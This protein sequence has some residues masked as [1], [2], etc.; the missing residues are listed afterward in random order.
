[1]V[2]DA[3]IGQLCITCPAAHCSTICG[4]AQFY[5][6]RTSPRNCRTCVPQLVVR[7]GPRRPV[8]HKIMRFSKFWV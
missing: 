4:C 7:K 2:Q 8:E 3:K 6:S 5:C 1:M